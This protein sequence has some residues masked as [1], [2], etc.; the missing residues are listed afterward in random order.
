MSLLGGVLGWAYRILHSNYP[1]AYCAALGSFTGRYCTQDKNLTKV[2]GNP[3]Y[4]YVD[5]AFLST[6]HFTYTYF[7]LD[8]YLKL[9]ILHYTSSRGLIAHIPLGHCCP[10]TLLSYDIC[11]ESHLDG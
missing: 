4:V 8:F 3:I 1:S 7:S 10:L 5:I 2:V 9:A 6:R 11:A